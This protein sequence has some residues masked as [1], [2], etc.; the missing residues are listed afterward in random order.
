MGFEM[1]LMEIGIYDNPL[2]KTTPVF[3]HLLW[4]VHGSRIC[5]SWCMKL[6][7]LH[8]SA[9]RSIFT[10]SA[11]AIHRSC[12]NIPKSF[13]ALIW[14]HSMFF[15]SIKRWSTYHVLFTAAATQLTET[16]SRPLKDGPPTT[17]SLCNSH[18]KQTTPCE[19][20]LSAGIVQHI[21]VSLHL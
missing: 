2:N 19:S 5:R 18:L 11:T 7:S 4:M 17:N 15:D 21:S 1:F 13:K 14:Q 20:G 3:Y 10:L 6:T 9:R 8:C 16:S 12:T